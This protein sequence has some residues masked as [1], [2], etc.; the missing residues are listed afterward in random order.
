MSLHAYSMT[1]NYVLRCTVILANNGV[2]FSDLWCI[3]VYS[4]LRGK[5][6][7]QSQARRKE[8]HGKMAQCAPEYRM[9]SPTGHRRSDSNVKNSRTTL[10]KLTAATGIPD[11]VTHRPPDQRSDSNVKNSRSTLRKLTAAFPPRLSGSL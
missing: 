2:K 8:R 1:V 6:G 11:G 4:A 10:W 3:L 5:S 7:T 9:V